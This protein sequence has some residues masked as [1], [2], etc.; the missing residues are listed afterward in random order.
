MNIGFFGEASIRFITGMWALAR[1]AKE[2]YEL[3]R[4]Y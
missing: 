4:I 1:A 2:T 3:S